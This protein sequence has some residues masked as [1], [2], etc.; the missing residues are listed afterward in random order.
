MQFWAP[1]PLANSTRQTIQLCADNWQGYQ[2]QHRTLLGGGLAATNIGDAQ[3]QS[4]WLTMARHLPIAFFLLVCAIAAI[5]SPPLAAGQAIPTTTPMGSPTTLPLTANPTPATATVTLSTTPPSRTSTI[6][7]SPTVP[8]TATVPATATGSATPTATGTPTAS[9]TATSSPTATRGTQ[10]ATTTPIA[11]APSTPAP[12]RARAVLATAVPT[13]ASIVTIRR[14]NVRDTSFT[15]VWTTDT[16]VAG[17]L[18]WG[19]SG[20]EPATAAYDRRGASATSTV[21]S[22][23]VNDLAPSTRYAFDIVSGAT[24]FTNGGAHFDV[25]TGPTLAVTAPDLASGRVTLGSGSTP[26]AALVWLQASN[27]TGVS[28]PVS[29]LVTAADAGSWVLDLGSLRTYD[30][31][32]AFAVTA[33]TVVTIQADGGA[34][35]KASLRTTVAEARAG[36]P[37]LTDLFEAPIKIGWNLVALRAT[38]LQTMTAEDLCLSL[39]GTEAGTALELARWELGAWESHLCGLPPNSFPME[40]GRGYFIRASRA[41]TWSYRGEQVLTPAPQPLTVGW[42]LVS[43]ATGTTSGPTVANTCT[44]LNTAYGAGAAVEFARWQSGAWEGHRC[45]IPPNNFT[46]DDGFGYFVRIAQPALWRTS[47]APN[48][49][50]VDAARLIAVSGSAVNLNLPNWP[51]SDLL[52]P[53]SV[54]AQSQV[55][56]LASAASD[57]VQAR[58]TTFIA[59]IPN[60]TVNASYGLACTLTILNSGT[61][62]IDFVPQV[63]VDSAFVDN[64]LWSDIVNGLQME[65]FID[66]V[67]RYLGPIDTSRS[68]APPYLERIAATSAMQYQVIIYLPREYKQGYGYDAAR[69]SLIVNLEYVF[70][71]Y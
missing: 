13:N 32:A 66:G 4:R 35:G 41:T 38:P 47:S 50:T 55:A 48:C 6:A 5:A 30:L 68:W 69:Q 34:S 56:V 19:P 40:T 3:M 43:V 57:T 14:T 20:T 71:R 37:V 59:R 15:I 62:P 21:H 1:F 16:A 67:S 29:T 51:R 2:I 31:S 22:V 17:Y 28:A 46:L 52:T 39:N 12:I 33:D 24:N 26:T 49:G 27:A 65:I 36:R 7:E 25:T 53:L 63:T 8:G 11:S 45:G 18:N 64:R 58:A 70:T 54:S 10:A 9:T 60:V 61:K 42:N 44:T 23:T